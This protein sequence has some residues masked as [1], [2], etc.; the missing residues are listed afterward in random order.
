[1][2]NE[3]TDDYI[4]E[5]WEKVSEGETVQAVTD[6]AKISRE[7]YY[8]KC[9][10]LGLK[11][12]TKLREDKDKNEITEISNMHDLAKIL[13]TDYDTVHIYSNLDKSSKSN[14][15]RMNYLKNHSPKKFQEAVMTTVINYYKLSPID[16]IKLIKDKQ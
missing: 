14:S 10:E 8:K 7:W 4:K 1:M 16:I 6:E 13:G 5:M 9:E 15:K 2:K 12:Q 3:I 11:T